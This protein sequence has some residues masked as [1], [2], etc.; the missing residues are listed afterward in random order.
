M[1]IQLTVQHTDFPTMERRG[2]AG[3]MVGTSI[4]WQSVMH[5]VELVASTNATVL[6][7]GETGT[8]KELLARSIH[9]RSA[10]RTRNMVVVDCGALPSSLIESELFGRERGAFTG[11]H[12]AQAG[13]F[14]MANGGT[15]FLDEIGELPL[16]LQPKLLR[17]L[18]E[19][20]VERLGCMRTTRVD[21]RIIAAT[22]RNLSDEVRRGRFRADLFY[23]LNVF[24]ITVP[25]L[26]DRPDDLPA[27][28]HHLADR[29]GRELGR[30]IERL[31][32]G[33]LEALARHHWPGNIRELENVLRRAIILSRN[34]LLDLNDF[35]GEPIDGVGAPAPIA[36][37]V[38]PLAEA[39]RD[40][41]NF[42]LEQVGWRVEGLA[43]A[44]QLLGLKPST[45]RSRMQKL[46]IERFPTPRPTGGIGAVAHS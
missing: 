4:A 42:V 37:R 25:P 35:V 26:R 41:V 31:A 40:H 13:R 16:E 7:L 8:G 21:I 38:R 6:L 43:G 46:G 22:N 2:S 29:V 12:T 11:A 10:R 23:R 14:E 33:S 36:S 5:R 15:V 3:A 32:P 19:G 34:G 24:P 1:A 44:A 39:E 17:V 30:P 27:L 9:E 18:Q 45:L 20:Q 28:V